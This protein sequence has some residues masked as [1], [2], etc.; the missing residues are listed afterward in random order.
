MQVFFFQQ[1]MYKYKIIYHMQISTSNAYIVLTNETDEI[2]NSICCTQIFSQVSMVSKHVKWHVDISRC[3]QVNGCGV[4][5][6][7]ELQ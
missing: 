4:Y 7:F 1:F 5:W 6:L 2:L 3:V